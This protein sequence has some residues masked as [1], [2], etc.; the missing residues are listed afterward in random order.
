MATGVAMQAKKTSRED[1]AVEIRAELTLD[2][3]RNPS[4]LLAGLRE[5]GLELL[6][7]DFVEQ[8]LLGLVAFVVDGW[9][10]SRDRANAPWSKSRAVRAASVG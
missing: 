5:E 10:S 4:P 9:G 7:N 2:E 1:A 6:S 8:G 3:S